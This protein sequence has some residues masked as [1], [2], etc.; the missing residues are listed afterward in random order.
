MSSLS[1]KIPQVLSKTPQVILGILFAIF[2]VFD[3]Y[4]SPLVAHR[5]DTPLG[6]IFVVFLFLLLFLCCHSFVAFLG[7]A[8]AYVL[9]QRSGFVTGKTFIPSEAKK[10]AIFDAN[11]TAPYTLEQ[12]IVTLRVPSQKGGYFQNTDVSFVPRLEN[13]HHAAVLL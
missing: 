11:P 9:I 7:I 2:L 6:Q 8:V 5:V 3:I 10:N 1:L 12:E 13:A 4:P